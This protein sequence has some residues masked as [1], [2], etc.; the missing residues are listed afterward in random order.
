[1]KK[2]NSLFADDDTMVQLEHHVC[3]R[4]QDPL[5]LKF[6]LSTQ[7]IGIRLKS[8]FRR[9]I[10]QT[11]HHFREKIFLFSLLFHI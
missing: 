4:E 5:L 10:W 1:M 8:R 2:G 3:A 9:S 11:N 7:P 6:Q